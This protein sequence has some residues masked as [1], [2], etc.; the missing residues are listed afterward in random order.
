MSIK[1]VYCAYI[2]EYKG[3]LQKATCPNCANKTKVTNNES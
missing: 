3:S 1:C 2:W